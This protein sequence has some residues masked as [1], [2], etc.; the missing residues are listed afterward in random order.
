[1]LDSL[2]LLASAGLR[3]LPP[4]L[5]LWLAI[6]F[7]RTLRAGRMPLVER[8]ARAALPA[9]SPAL[10]RYTRGLTAAWCVYFV[11]AAVLSLAA[12]PGFRAASSGVAAVS[13]LFFVGEHW[14]RTRVFFRDE[15]FPGLIQQIRDTASVWRV[16]GPR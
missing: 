1:M 16:R 4:L 3:Y 2:T 15:A 7:G 14:L 9:L 11:A 13:A 12:A 8:I 5:L 6:F 10:C